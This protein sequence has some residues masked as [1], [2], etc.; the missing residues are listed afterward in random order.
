GRFAPP[1]APA[2]PIFERLRMNAPSQP[3]GETPMLADEEATLSPRAPRI[4]VPADAPAA[5]THTARP[6]EF[7]LP[8]KPASS[9]IP[10]KSRN[11]STAP[12]PP[13][14][15]F[16]DAWPDPAQPR[17]EPSDAFARPNGDAL[18]SALAREAENTPATI[19]KSGVV[20]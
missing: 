19:L 4:P 13:R 7:R 2:D 12:Q 10:E 3:R 14:P 16:N 8:P 20:D 17:G 9:P 15:S 5:E 1:D 11:G 6:G 18:R